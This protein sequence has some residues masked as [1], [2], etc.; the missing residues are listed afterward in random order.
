MIDEF[1]NEI[2]ENKMTS[3]RKKIAANKNLIIFLSGV[4]ILT[5][6]ILQTI[7]TL[8]PKQNTLKQQNTVLPTTQITPKTERKI[9][10]IASEAT[11]LDL[12]EK[13]A[14]L[15]SQIE[16]EDMYE[17]SLV[18]PPVDTNVEIKEQNNN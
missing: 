1:G 18:F 6:V 15:S 16:Q 4:F 13:T 17:S 2:Q 9:S 7:F 8:F 10:K 12:E 14:S 3:F 5:L 11:F